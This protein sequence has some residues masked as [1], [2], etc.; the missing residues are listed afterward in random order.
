VVVVVVVVVVVGA[1]VPFELHAT[2]SIPA[3]MAMTPNVNGTRRPIRAMV[4]GISLS[5]QVTT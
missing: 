3:A 2:D 4:N 1:V 5:S